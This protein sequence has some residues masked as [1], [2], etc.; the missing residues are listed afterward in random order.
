MAYR[1]DMMTGQRTGRQLFFGDDSMTRSAG[2]GYWY[3]GQDPPPDWLAV[4]LEEEES[5]VAELYA[6]QAGRQRGEM[7]PQIDSLREKLATVA[8]GLEWTE[9][10]S[11]PSALRRALRRYPRETGA[12]LDILDELGDSLG[13]DEALGDWLLAQDEGGREMSTVWR[14]ASDNLLERLHLEPATAAT[15][16]LEWL[17]PGEGRTVRVLAHRLEGISPTTRRQL[18]ES[19]IAAFRLGEDVHLFD[20]VTH[21]LAAWEQARAVDLEGSP[22]TLQDT[23]LLHELTEVAVTATEGLGPAAAHVVAA[24]MGRMCGRDEELAAATD[25]Y[26]SDQRSSVG[27]DPVR[28]PR[29]WQASAEDQIPVMVVD[30][31]SMSRHVVATLLRRLGHRAVEAVDGAEAVS[32]AEAEQPRLIILD[33]ELP[34]VDGLTALTRLRQIPDHEST[35]TIILTS[36]RDPES[37]VE[38]RRLGVVDYVAKPIDTKDLTRR[39]GQYLETPTPG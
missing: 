37:I 5:R 17:T 32:Q 12:S 23:L 4:R 20:S 18:A 13:T 27:L 6:V 14:P 19:A 2:I 16:M 22:L 8:A 31:S 34:D 26:F 9:R 11:V 24:V 10:R 3:G 7:T 1:L 29:S 36:N 38:A 15:W 21:H 25:L 28:S 30:D 35:P 33:I 39:I